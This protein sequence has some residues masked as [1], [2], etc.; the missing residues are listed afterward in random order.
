M[1]KKIR[2]H[3]NAFS[4]NEYRQSKN[5]NDIKHVL[6]EYG[7]KVIFISHVNLENYIR[8]KEPQ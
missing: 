4:Y 1:T 3:L 6:S 5:C 2:K 8:K 7:C